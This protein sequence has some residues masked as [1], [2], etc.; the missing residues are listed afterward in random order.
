[1]FSSVLVLGIIGL[2]Q[3]VPPARP[4]VT[5]KPAPPQPAIEA[6]FY[7]QNI[8]W[9]FEADAEGTVYICIYLPTLVLANHTRLI[10]HGSC[11]TSASDC[12]GLHRAAE[13]RALSEPMLGSRSR[14]NPANAGLICQKISDDGGRTWSK[15]RVVAKGVFTG[16]IVWDDVRKVGM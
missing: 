9:P 8:F 5:P 13:A 4:P 2:A 16:Q 15:I 1:M 3:G 6:G 14:G 12:N 10:A 11:A 7:S